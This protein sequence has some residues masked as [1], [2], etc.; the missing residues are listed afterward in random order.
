VSAPTGTTASGAPLRSSRGQLLALVLAGGEGGRLGPLTEHR[1]KPALPFGGVYRL[2]DFPL[3]NCHHSRVSDVWVLQ[4]YEAHSLSEHLSNGRP[5]DLDRT[6]GGL[7]VVQPYTGDPESG[8]YEGNADAIYRNREAIEEFAPELVL[9]V[10]ADAPYKLHYGEVVDEHVE[11]GA[12]VTIVTT[13]VPLEEAG[14]FGVVEV[15]G[16]GRVTGFEYKPEQPAGGIVT[17]EVFV[18][19]ADVLLATLTEL[20]D[21][22]RG[23]EDFG[24][25]LLPRLVEN[26]KAYARELGGYWR[27]VGTIESYWQAH[28]DLLGPEPA[29][30]LD[31]REWPIL[32][33]ASQRPPARIDASARIDRSLV[34]P[35]CRIAGRVERSVLGPGVVVEEGAEVVESVV[36]DD[37]R[38]AARVQ[39]AIVDIDG[40]VPDEVSGEDEIAVVA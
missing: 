3:S 32:T 15:D 16:G 35:G 2:I 18:Y 21:G 8:F 17:T 12:E 39:R 13:E 20:A 4:Q 30:E 36:L 11:R 25:A 23:L 14:R 40:D 9:V 19:D 33:M 5:W 29:L 10:S 7:R 6:F 38:I 26:G 27:D 24:D 28:M 22:D 37:A 1:A 31:D 34:S